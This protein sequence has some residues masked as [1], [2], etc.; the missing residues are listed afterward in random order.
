MDKKRPAHNQNVDEFVETYTSDPASGLSREEARKRLDQ[1]GKNELPAEEKE[2]RWKAFMRHFHDILIYVLLAAAAITLILGHYIDTAVILV[3]AV[4]NAGIGYFQENKAEKALEGIRNMLSLEANVRRDGKRHTVSSSEL[5]VGDLVMLSPGDKVP[6]DLRLIRAEELNVEEAA[7]TGESTSVLKHTEPLEK[8]AVLADRLNMVFSGTTVVSGTGAGIVAATGVKTEIGKINRSMSDIEDIKTPLLRQTAQFGKMISVAIV[9]LAFVMFVFGYFFRDYEIGELFLSV[10]ALAVAAIPEG[11]PAILSIILAIGVQN[12][13]GRNA[14]VRNLPS[15]ETLG[16]VSVICSDKTGTLTKN[17][18]TVTSVVTADREYNVSGTG[19]APTGTIFHN[20]EEADTRKDSALHHFL[21]SVKN[22][23]DA[24]LHQDEEGHWG[25]MGEPTEGCLVTL[26]EKASTVVDELTV[27]SKIPFDSDYKYMATLVTLEGQKMMLI[28]GAPDRIFDMAEQ[29]ALADGAKQ[30]FNRDVWT[31]K[32]GAH[33]KHGERVLGVAIKPMPEDTE[34]ITRAD[35]SEGVT[36]LGLAGIIDPPRDAAVRAITECKKAGIQVKM[37]TGDHA[38]TAMAIGKQMGIETGEAALEGKDLDAMSQE[39]LEEA[40]EK[41]QIF[42]R[43]SPENKLRLLEALQAKGKIAAMTGDGV[44]DAAALKRADVGVAMGIKGTEV[45]KDAS[46]MVL[47]DD[48]FKTIVNAVEE[49]RRVYDNLKKTILFILPT[50]A[51]Q[52]LLIM[53]SIL[54][55]VAMPLSPVQILWVNMVTSVTISLALAFETLDKGTME[56]SPRHPNTPLLS[57]YYIFRILFV[58]FLIG[59]GTLAINFTMIG[60]GYDQGIVT[61]VT[62]QMI[63]LAQMFHLFNC[64]SELNFA[65]NKDFFKNKAV[66]VVSAILIGLQLAITYV[67]FMNTIFGTQPIEL[68]HWIF[69]IIMGI[70][71]FIVVEIEK[72]ITKQIVK[73][74]GT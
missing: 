5:V 8:N 61:T 10:I 9:G 29:E 18:M 11:L 33:A 51:A 67:P 23:N 6:A 27:E 70:V 59:G 20:E 17:E 55:G 21:L 43:T 49:G 16:S 62:L 52:A 46:E 32:M 38:E 65:F 31:Q 15:V 1:Y 44:N 53:A 57:G 48:H 74:K 3:V 12:M 73:R 14:I 19:Y 56:R 47:V 60:Q 4:V 72:A 39:E 71:V 64:R 40:V 7:L 45:A 34:K 50:N 35:L 63:V 68:A 58:A 13:A 54:I 25:I 24:E 42:A 69:P 28:K 41:Y 30:P 66:F 26:A 36:M 22:N 2:P 37:I